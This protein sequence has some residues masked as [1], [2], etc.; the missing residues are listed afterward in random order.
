[1]TNKDDIISLIFPILKRFEGFVD[2]PYRDVA[3]V[4]TIGYGTTQYPNGQKVRYGDP[5]ITQGQAEEYSLAD[6]AD[7]VTAVADLVTAPATTG[8][9]AAL[10]DFS[11]NL[12]IGA[13]RSSTLLK[14]LNAGDYSGAAAE[15]GKWT[16]ARQNGVLVVQP[17]LVARRNAERDLFLS[18]GLPT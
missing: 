7:R 8:M 3:G 18:E 5:K 11:Y 10:L 13:L 2:H 14:K 17:G 6:L 9:L 12:G 16:K 15:F 4:W 1:M